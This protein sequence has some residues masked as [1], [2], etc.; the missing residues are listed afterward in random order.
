MS[1]VVSSLYLNM[2]N[3]VLSTWLSWSVL[4]VT[5]GPPINPEVPQSF[6]NQDWLLWQPAAAHLFHCRWPWSLSPLRKVICHQNLKCCLPSYFTFKGAREGTWTHGSEC[7]LFQTVIECLCCKFCVLATE[8]LQQFSVLQVL[9]KG[10][11]LQ[12][13]KSLG[14]NKIPP[15]PLDIL[16]G[17]CLQT[18]DLCLGSQ[19]KK[20]VWL[21]LTNVLQ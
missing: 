18:C 14:T 5:A 19:L 15:V 13:L 10:C 8:I 20:P 9:R 7:R 11:W 16:S 1:H 3:S 12:I 2:R 17:P 4:F 21:P 6:C